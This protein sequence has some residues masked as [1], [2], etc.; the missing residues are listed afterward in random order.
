M[1]RVTCAV[2]SRRRRK[3]ILKKAKGFFGDRK[4]HIRQSKDAVRKAMAYSTRDRAQRKRNFRRLWI[5]RIN[6]ASRINGLS[7]SRLING[8]SKAGCAFDRKTLA[9]LAVNDPTTFAEIA[10]CAKKA[11]A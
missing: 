7:Y 11:L 5:A 3:R 1:V 6:V 9:D 10:T 4:N 8:L 2:A